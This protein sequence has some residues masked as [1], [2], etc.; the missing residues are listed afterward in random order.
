MSSELNKGKQTVTS[1]GSLILSFL[2]SSHHW[3][4]MVIMMLI[5]GSMGT[6]S[7]MSGTM[8]AIVW[9][10]RF[11]IVATLLTAGFSMYRLY[12]HK[13]KDRKMIGL[14]FL[15]SVISVGFVV[16]TLVDFGW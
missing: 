9:F 3:I 11:M 6:M 4:H 8:S 5:T 16:Y 2:A 14:T 7:N 13:C 12:R 15:S 10:R 1:V